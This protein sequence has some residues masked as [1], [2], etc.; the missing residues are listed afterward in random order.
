[1][2]SGPLKPRSRET[3]D[4]GASRRQFLTS[5]AIAMVP[6]AVDS[7]FTEPITQSRDFEYGNPLRQLDYGDLQFAPGPH[8][9]Q[10]QQTHAVLV[11]LDEEGLLRPF[12]L[13]AGLA[14]PVRSRWLVQ[15]YARHV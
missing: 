9:A 3:V 4:G 2:S 12:R 6:L 7:A 14:A 13:S 11:G 8:Q 10:L 15:H 5:A 1:M